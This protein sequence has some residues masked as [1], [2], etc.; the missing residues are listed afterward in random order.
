MNILKIC[1]FGRNLLWNHIFNQATFEYYHCYKLWITEFNEVFIFIVILLHF[2]YVFFVIF[3]YA[4]DFVVHHV[5]YIDVWF[6]T[7]SVI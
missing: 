3:E 2:L 5:K 6:H 1:N 4:K 7:Q